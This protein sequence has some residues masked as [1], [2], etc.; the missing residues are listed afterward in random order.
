MKKSMLLA[1]S[2]TVYSL[3]G[4]NTA[5][6]S[7][8]Q[9]ENEAR[10]N[11][12]LKAHNLTSEEFRHFGN[13]YYNDKG[14]LVIQFKN[15]PSA[16]S[17]SS[18][19]TDF[20]DEKNIIVENVQYSE[21][22]LFA[23]QD[24]FSEKT[25]HLNL[26]KYTK[27]AMNEESNGLTLQT[28]SLTDEQKQQISALYKEYGED[29]IQFDID[30]KYEFI[31]S[32]LLKDPSV[33]VTEPSNEVSSLITP[34]AA[35]TRYSNF[36]EL[37]GGIGLKLPSGNTCTTTGV[38]FKGADYFIVT[39]GHCLTNEFG[40]FRQYDA[41]IGESHL[42]SGPF[43]FGLVKI[44]QSG[45]LPD[46]RWATNKLFRET[47]KGDYDARINAVQRPVK[48]DVVSKSGT[49]TDKT[50]GIVTNTRV[51]SYLDGREF[52]EV[53]SDFVFADHGDSGGPVYN[54]NNELLGLVSQYGDKYGSGKVIYNTHLIDAANHYGVSIY[55]ANTALR[56]K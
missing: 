43:D 40:L 21:V 34:L 12:V 53:T 37:G 20:A 32:P 51:V 48:L 24:E 41:P 31:P 14:E 10:F 35:K 38:G 50:V 17:A 33:T 3:F 52:F 30:S 11:A 28:P 46:G 6:A 49:Y 22:D 8:L 23:I 47:S 45:N 4:L 9:E 2:L 1:L 26:S 42:D 19:L 56:I 18:L 27:I 44:T 55:T 13:R 54:E 15:N 25:K 29:F 16:K 39:A 5:E 7:S 36:S